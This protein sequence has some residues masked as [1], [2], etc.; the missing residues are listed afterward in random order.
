MDDLEQGEL[1]RE[2]LKANGAAIATGIG[3]GLAGLLGWQWWQNNTVQHQ[4]DAA[5]TFQSLQD[6]AE[7]DDSARVEQF[8]AELSDKFAK[9]SYAT[10]ALLRLAEEK[11]A[12]G[13]TDAA[14]KAL[15]DGLDKAHSPALEALVRLR[16]ARVQLAVGQAQEALD[17]LAKIPADDY[18]GLVAETRGD[19]LLALGRSDDAVSAYRDAMTHLDTGALNRGIIQMK[20]ADLGVAD[21]EPGA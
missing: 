9:T 12:Q 16:L 7:V 6:A 19:A 10:L 1:V 13:D 18:A 5:T 17:N 21:S 20:L 14:M 15:T 3:L 11:V 2:W 4:L 8:A